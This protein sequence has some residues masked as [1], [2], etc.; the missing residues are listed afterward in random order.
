MN[1]ANPTFTCNGVQ[2]PDVK[3]HSD[4]EIEKMVAHTRWANYDHNWLAKNPDNIYEYCSLFCIHIMELFW[5]ARLTM[6][7][8]MVGDKE[9]WQASYWKNND[10]G[11][12]VQIFYSTCFNQHR[13]IA[14]ALV[15]LEFCFENELVQ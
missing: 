3:Q 11:S 4:F 7:P 6:K 2:I 5:E 13:A 14:E 15:M 1:I 12:Q 9:A 8:V 10:D